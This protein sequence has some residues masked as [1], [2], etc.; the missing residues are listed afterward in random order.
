MRISG[1]SFVLLKEF[2]ASIWLPVHYPQHRVNEEP[3][4]H[5]KWNNFSRGKVS[6][7]EAEL[8]G[9]TCT[10]LLEAGEIGMFELS[11]QNT[12]SNETLAPKVYSIWHKKDLRAPVFMGVGS[13]LRV[14]LFQVSCGPTLCRRQCCSV[15]PL[16]LKRQLM[17]AF[18]LVHVTSTAIRT[19]LK[20]S[21]LSPSAA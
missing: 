18:V 11:P 4:L 8:W 6:S 21:L 1:L 13:M 20:K 12:V 15:V 19:S 10:A 7:G 5:S 9:G 14:R 3:V 2:K 17:P 16:T